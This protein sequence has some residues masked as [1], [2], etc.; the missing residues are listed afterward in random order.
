MKTSSNHMIISKIDHTLMSSRQAT[1]VTA[2]TLFSLGGGV[3]GVV[4]EA[5]F[6][7][8]ISASCP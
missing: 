3:C 2:V 4:C 7:V 6:H 1:C 8:K 5:D